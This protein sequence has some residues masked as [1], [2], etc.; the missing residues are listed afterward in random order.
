M[1][2]HK[3]TKPTDAKLFNRGLAVFLKWGP[4]QAKPIEQRLA[5]VVGKLSAKAMAQ[6]I[7]EYGEIQSSACARVI[8]QLETHQSEEVG[9]NA[10]AAIDPRLSSKNASTLYSQARIWAARDGYG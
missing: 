5:K 9:R 10:V 8:E 4:A 6:V 7:R 1:P 3:P 2:A